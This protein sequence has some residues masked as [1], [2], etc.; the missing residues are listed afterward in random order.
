MAVVPAHLMRS[1]AGGF[2][3]EAVAVP[4]ITLVFYLWIKAVKSRARFSW[5]FG[6]M[7]GVAYIYL[8]SAWGA[9]F[10]SEHIAFMLVWS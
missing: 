8:V 2:D 6:A 9:H 1:V 5:V 3:N 4:A 7:S 10:C